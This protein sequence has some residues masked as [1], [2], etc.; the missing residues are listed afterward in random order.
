MKIYADILIVL[1]VLKLLRSYLPTVLLNTD[2]GKKKWKNVKLVY[3][4]GVT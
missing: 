4:F 1:L 3:V 2:L